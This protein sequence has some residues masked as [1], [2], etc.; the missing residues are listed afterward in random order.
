MIGLVEPLCAAVIAHTRCIVYT[1]CIVS[2]S[3]RVVVDANLLLH[4]SSCL[5][6]FVIIFLAKDP[7]FF[8]CLFFF[9]HMLLLLIVDC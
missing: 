2:Y 7:A 1:R 4:Q 5:F 9:W 3:S 6:C 8:L